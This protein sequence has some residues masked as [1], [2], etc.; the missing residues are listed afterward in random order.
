MFSDSSMTR[1]LFISEVSSVPEAGFDASGLE[2]LWKHYS[3]GVLHEVIFNPDIVACDWIQYQCPSAA[4][5]DLN[6][7]YVK[8]LIRKEDGSRL[9]EMDIRNLT[10][11]EILDLM[12]MKLTVLECSNESILVCIGDC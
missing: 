5:R 6:E 8:D 10:E 4:V 9:S 2:R 1:E 3:E 12:K 11:G 7:F